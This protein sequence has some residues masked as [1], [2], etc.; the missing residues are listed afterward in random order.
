MGGR[1]RGRQDGKGGRR[2]VIWGGWDSVGEPE[3]AAAKEIVTAWGF[4]ADSIKSDG[5]EGSSAAK[6]GKAQKK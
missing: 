4:R 6:D 5:D 1:Q 3:V 2:A